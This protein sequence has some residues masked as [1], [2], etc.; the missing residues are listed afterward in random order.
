M[1]E[2]FPE[3]WTMN[4]YKME[5]NKSKLKKYKNSGYKKKNFISFQRGEK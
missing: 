3:I 1:W 4:L 5:E 2:I